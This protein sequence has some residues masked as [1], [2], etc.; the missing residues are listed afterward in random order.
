M[1]FRNGAVGSLEPFGLCC[2]VLRIV[3]DAPHA[4][5][6]WATLEQ[7]RFVATK[8]NPKRIDAWGC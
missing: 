3:A 7:R 1:R 4:S 5:T 8:K 6:K 2:V